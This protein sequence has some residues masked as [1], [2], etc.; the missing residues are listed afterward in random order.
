MIRRLKA[1]ILSSVC[2]PNAIF[3]RLASSSWK[4]LLCRAGIN[5]SRRF[6]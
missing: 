3:V 4:A 2:S 1:A 5:D 6:Y